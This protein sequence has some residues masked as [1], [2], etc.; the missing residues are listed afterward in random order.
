M[1]NLD[2]LQGNVDTRW[3]Y[4]VDFYNK[5]K[6]S[7]ESI[8]QQHWEQLFVDPDFFG[9]SKAFKEIDSQRK[10]KLGSTEKV[11]SDIV[12][13]KD[14][15][16]IFLIEL[17]KY[18]L[19]FNDGF[20]RQLFSYLKLL[21]LDIGIL[22]CDKIYLVY[23]DKE[24]TENQQEFAEIDFELDSLQ[25]IEF[26]EIFSRANFD[27]I[28]T[29]NFINRQIKFKQNIQRIKKEL[30]NKFCKELLKT[31]FCQTYS[32]GEVFQALKTIDIQIIDNKKLDNVNQDVTK[33]KK[34]DNLNQNLDTD[35]QSS[36]D[37]GYNPSNRFSFAK[38]GIP[39]D[40][41]IYF[42]E[43]PTFFAS[44]LDDNKVFFEGQQYSLSGLTA[45]IKRRLGT[46]NSSQSYQGARY[47][48][49]N[50]EVL[51]HLPDIY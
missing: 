27:K 10:I 29:I 22:I 48:L 41:I 17:K 33:P 3:S 9:Y 12:V 20:A 36:I 38:K 34:I 18:S 7:A 19:E 47:W 40:S 50:D 15:K 2:L 5:N 4:I 37:N 45:L 16:D 1:Q 28:E 21:S 42:R 32:Q 26:I 6:N 30:D 44:V 31:H 14:K 13:K 43:D 35:E 25:G 8:I 39:K 49:Y 23:Y 51:Y 46:A 24:K 11:L